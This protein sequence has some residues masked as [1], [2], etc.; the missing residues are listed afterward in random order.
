MEKTDYSNEGISKLMADLQWKR[1]LEE[2]KKKK[3]AGALEAVK[4]M[5]FRKMQ[6][7]ILYLQN[8]ILP[9]IA[10]RKA[11]KDGPDYKFFQG[12]IESL[13]WALIMYDR[14]DVLMGRHS[15]LSLEKTILMERVALYEKELTKYTTMED[16]YLSE[17]LDVIDKGVR[18]RI[19]T[20]TEGQKG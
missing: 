11:G 15:L 4:K 17:M 9:A 3:Y 2:S 6:D 13:K 7:E 18:D 5:P 8:N 14:L 20:L 10:A 12:L 19:K 16:L 1:D